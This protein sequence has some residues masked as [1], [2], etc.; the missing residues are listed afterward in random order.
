MQPN[1]IDLKKSTD[2]LAICANNLQYVGSRSCWRWL[3]W[4]C[5][6]GRPG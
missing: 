5:V 2:W 1:G 3:P 4:R 6:A